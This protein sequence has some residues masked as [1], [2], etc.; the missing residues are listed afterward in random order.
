MTPTT[1]APVL[2]DREA[3]GRRIADLE[4]DHVERRRAL[5]VAS[6]DA[7]ALL[8][9]ARRELMAAQERAG[10]AA[11]ELYAA[12][13]NLERAVAECRAELRRTAPIDIDDFGD[14]LA[15]L[16]DV[17]RRFVVGDGFLPGV[18]DAERAIPDLRDLPVA[19]SRILERIDE[20][21]DAIPTAGIPPATLEA[22]RI[23]RTP[24]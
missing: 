9:V 13:R 8:E 5:A 18:R 21:R 1:T 3:I 15:R 19:T 14:E 6:A 12:E 2:D 20:L 7:D 24:R 10:H 17:A 11:G 16:R 23:R 4:A 22:I